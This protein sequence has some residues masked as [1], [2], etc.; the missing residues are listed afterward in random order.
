MARTKSTQIR[1]PKMQRLHNA[2]RLFLIGTLL[3]AT[4]TRAQTPVTKAAETPDP[5]ALLARLN[6]LSVLSDRITRCAVQRHLGVL[7]T[8][9]E[10]VLL[11]AVREAR[12]QINE[13]ASLDKSAT[14]RAPWNSARTTYRTY[15]Q[16]AEKLDPKDRDGLA[17]LA[18]EA[19][20]LD[21]KVTAVSDQ[22]LKES[23]TPLASILNVTTEMQRL[24][25]HLAVHF[26][27]ARAGIDEKANTDEVSGSRVTFTKLLSE[28]RASPIQ[29]PVI[30]SQLQLLE[31]QWIFMNSALG[32]TVRNQQSLEAAC[33]TSERTLEVLTQLYT[34]FDTT[35]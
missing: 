28:L 11:S 1:G 29:S 17:R 5:R 16:A 6:R 9:A 3:A 10:K 24:T 4:V 32:A 18:H 13:L 35:R 21:D 14:L 8:Q 20:E 2:R 27:L 15:L 7:T 26:L 12:D 34:Q 25:Q 33:T 31:G 19:D 23:G 22:I 30:G